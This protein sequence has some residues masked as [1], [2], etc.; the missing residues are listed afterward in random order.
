MQDLEF[1]CESLEPEIVRV[2]KLAV[3]KEKFH[4]VPQIINKPDDYLFS[5]GAHFKQENFEYGDTIMVK[6]ESPAKMYFMTGE[7]AIK[8]WNTSEQESTVVEKTSLGEIEFFEKLPT[9]LFNA[10]SLTSLTV[11]SIT[12]E[13]LE[14]VF[15]RLIEKELKELKERA[16][17]MHIR[18]CKKLNVE[19]PVFRSPIV[20][21]ASPSRP[22]SVLPSS[23]T[24][25]T[26]RTG[27]SSGRSGK[28]GQS[29]RR[30]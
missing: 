24:V 16:Q 28:S 15:P 23:R 10:R 3:Y 11:F 26:V 4:S 5:L 25:R 9:R 19:E 20:S 30:K 14:L 7:G 1:I 18:L 13:T 12:Y 29:K 27:R 6:G 22:L 21:T 2:L 8:I 17:R